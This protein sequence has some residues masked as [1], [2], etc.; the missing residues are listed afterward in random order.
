MSG[1][2]IL[3]PCPFCGSMNTNLGYSGQPGVTAYVTCWECDTQGPSITAYSA[4]GV[5]TGAQWNEAVNKW[6]ERRAANGA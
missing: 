5:L 6:N 4:T 3:K 2:K 1:V